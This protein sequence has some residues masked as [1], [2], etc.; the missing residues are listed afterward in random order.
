MSATM[1]PVIVLVGRSN[2]GKS[3]LFNRLTG[4]SRALVAEE[5]G[6]TRDRQYASGTL[7]DRPYLAVDTGGLVGWAPPDALSAAMS[8]QAWQ[9]VRE[10]DAVILLADG[11]SGP[12]A[13]DREIVEALRKQRSR[14][15]L[16]VN[17]TE[18][19]EPHIATADFHDL[20]MGEPYAISAAH[21][22]RVAA[23]MQQVLAELPKV[24]DTPAIADT[25]EIA[26][27]GRPNVGKSTLVNT[28]LGEQRVVVSD[29]PGTTRD[30]VRIPLERAG[31]HYVLI[32]T[33]GVRRRASARDAVEKFSVIRTLRAIEAANVAV[34]VLD[35]HDGISDQDALLG[36]HILECGRAIVVVVNKW[37]VLDQEQRTRVKNELERKLRFLAFART[38]FIS[39]LQ[40]TR[41]AGLFASVDRAFTSARKTL[42]TPKLN[43]VL[44]GAVRA[45]APPRASSGA[46][47]LKFAH[48]GGKNPPLIVIH[49]TRV[50]RIPASYRRYL[51]RSIRTGFNLEGTPVRIAFRAGDNPF[52]GRTVRR[53]RARARRKHRA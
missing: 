36:G 31:R 8:A 48:Q 41:I 5:E 13:E 35:A 12:N 28:L 20:G 17:K 22:D 11:R 52:A 9:A 49:G 3:T 39:A 50:E 43:R 14:V 18:G 10:A 53:T 34:L 47:R 44:Q 16:V 51:A 4:G 25:P 21:G 40:G 29:S 45:A 6:L 33:A 23:L 15:W 26:I 38:H 27:V 32:D 24:N 1:K 46:V 19:M 37:D 30:S 2:V 42:T 7:G